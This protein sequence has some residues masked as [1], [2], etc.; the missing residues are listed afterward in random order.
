MKLWAWRKLSFLLHVF[1][2]LSHVSAVRFPDFW[3]ESHACVGGEDARTL[4]L[5]PPWYGLVPLSSDEVPSLFLV[6][7]WICTDPR[8]SLRPAHP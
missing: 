4:G 1:C 3:L 5:Q 6:R 8:P 2:L 7:G